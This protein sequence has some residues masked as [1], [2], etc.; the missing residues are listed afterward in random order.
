[1]GGEPQDIGPILTDEQADFIND[2]HMNNMPSSAIARVMGRMLARQESGVA[3]GD[4]R[5]SGIS[6]GTA[7]PGY[8]YT[9]N[10]AE[11][12]PSVPSR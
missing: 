10:S 4:R 2:L 3:G 7:P 5:L 12:P 8:E 1:M 11:S 9:D 6:I